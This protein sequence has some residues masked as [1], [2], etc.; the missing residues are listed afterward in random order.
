LSARCTDLLLRYFD[1][2]FAA[3]VKQGS[4]SGA[5]DL[6]EI[7]YA[8]QE[9]GLEG[10]QDAACNRTDQ[11]YEIKKENHPPKQII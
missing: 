3:L 10:T 8:T 1:T 5:S 2:H 4:S 9:D 7:C 11:L 6:H